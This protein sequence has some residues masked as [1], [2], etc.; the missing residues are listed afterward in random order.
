MKNC[1]KKEKHTHTG[2]VELI[3]IGMNTW[4]PLEKLNSRLY[5]HLDS[6]YST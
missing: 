6:T 1:M 5:L 3:P 2:I 4:W